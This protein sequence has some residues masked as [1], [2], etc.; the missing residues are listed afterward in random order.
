MFKQLS[1]LLLSVL[2]LTAQANPVRALGLGNTESAALHHA[3][4]RAIESK[5]GV[6]VLN[7]LELNKDSIAKDDIFNYSSAYVDKFNIVSKETRA[8]QHLVE[9]D[10]WV[11]ES[12]LA[13][14]ILHK[15]NTRT[16]I[17]GVR[18]QHQHQTYIATKQQ[19]DKLILKTLEH[20]PS[21]AFDIVLKDSNFKYDSQRQL[22]YSADL[23]VGWS[24]N[25]ID[26]LY[27]TLERL[28]D[29]NSKQSQTTV[30]LARTPNHNSLF[31]TASRRTFYFNDVI[32]RQ[33]L[34]TELK[35]RAPVLVVSFSNNN[36]LI[37]SQCIDIAQREYFSP[38]Y[39]NLDIKAY[40]PGNKKVK[41]NLGSIDLS[42]ITDVKIT[43]IGRDQ[44]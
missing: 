43:I 35:K 18:L 20:Y 2:C 16:D 5:V 30:L 24:K 44:C 27:E 3:F 9:V 7:E 36:R 19:G 26:A 38:G 29:S 12:K 25:F 23:T 42:S 28:E 6:L 13:N 22:H 1:V 15:N 34:D 40:N 14:R 8:G 33:L 31:N 10:V 41:L 11:S 37:K 17:D 39:S 32:T 21:R 4:Q